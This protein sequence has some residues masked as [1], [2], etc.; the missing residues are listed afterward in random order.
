MMR[1]FAKSN[2]NDQ[3]VGLSSL[4]LDSSESMTAKFSLGDGEASTR[5]SD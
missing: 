4:P 5:R 3:T 2:Q 1:F